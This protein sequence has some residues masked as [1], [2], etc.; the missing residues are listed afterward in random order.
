M[1]YYDL[2]RQKH[3]RAVLSGKKA[4]NIYRV[5]SSNETMFGDKRIDLTD[6]IIINGKKYDEEDI[7]I[8][9]KRYSGIPG[10]YEL[11]FMKFPVEILF[12]RVL[13]SRNIKALAT[14]VH[15]RGRI[16]Q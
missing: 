2:L 8:D 4:D 10:L 6:D 9:G 16:I 11:I 14:N 7:I 13:I 15:R 1:L 12:I 5:F 3:L